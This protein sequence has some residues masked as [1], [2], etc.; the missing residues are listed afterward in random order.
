MNSTQ[1]TPHEIATEKW[2]EKVNKSRDWIVAYA[3]F[4]AFFFALLILRAVQHHAELM[5]E[6][7][8]VT[9]LAL[10]TLV[11]GCFTFVVIQFTKEL[12]IYADIRS[13]KP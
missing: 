2:G 1:K 12:F 11:A 3:G 8:D 13:Q 5:K 4:I 6:T 7:H 10:S 9:G